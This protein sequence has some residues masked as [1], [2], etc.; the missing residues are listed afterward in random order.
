MK[1]I[2]WVLYK[3]DE[4]SSIDDDYNARVEG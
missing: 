2:G 3:L 4:H 1:V